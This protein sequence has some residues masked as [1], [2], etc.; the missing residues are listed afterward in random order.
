MRWTKPK[1]GTTRKRSGF[2]FFPRGIN[3][4]VRWLERAV[5]EQRYGIMSWHDNEWLND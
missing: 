5:W 1:T 4:N 3:R 2:L